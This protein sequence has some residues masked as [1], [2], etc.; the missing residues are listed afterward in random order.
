MTKEQY[1]P[2]EV[3]TQ[4][5]NH[6]KFPKA[7]VD[8]ILKKEQGLQ[9]VFQIICLKYARHIIARAAVRLE[10]GF[11]ENRFNEKHH[12]D[13]GDIH[14]TLGQQEDLVKALFNDVGG[15]SDET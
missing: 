13:L 7:L 12:F 4:W 8:Q 10:T 2:E 3:Y 6:A 9:E 15:L 14:L 11:Q 5:A 1:T